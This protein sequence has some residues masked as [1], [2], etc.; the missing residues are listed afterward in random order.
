MFGAVDM[1]DSGR[2]TGPPRH[3][4]LFASP[5]HLGLRPSGRGVVNR[6][7]RA[8]CECYFL[9]AWDFVEITRK[10]NRGSS[11][12]LFYR[13]D[14]RSR[15]GGSSSSGGRDHFGGF[16]CFGFGGRS[17]GG[18]GRGL[19]PSGR[20]VLPICSVWSA[21]TD[22]RQSLRWWSYTAFG[23]GVERRRAASGDSRTRLARGVTSR[24]SEWI[25]CLRVGSGHHVLRFTSDELR[26]TVAIWHLTFG[27][28]TSTA[29]ES[30]ARS[31]TVASNQ[32]V[33]LGPLPRWHHTPNEPL[34][35]AEQAC[36]PCPSG[37]IRKRESRRAGVPRECQ[38]TITPYLP[39]F[40]V[41]CGTV[42]D[43]KSMEGT[44]VSTSFSQPPWVWLST[45]CDYAR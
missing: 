21:S 33:V 7:C 28:G 32:V 14:G 1:I 16:G 6:G 12:S 26:A 3:T 24:S 35:H 43:G 39:P 45:A 36:L 13:F 2:A 42:L 15:L 25:L 20:L 27:F 38:D 22:C 37:Y 40:G 31:E 8:W 23:E 17:I 30:S 4:T 11:G 19:L 9:L 5:R 10:R 41:V 29:M 44:L 34:P 18:P